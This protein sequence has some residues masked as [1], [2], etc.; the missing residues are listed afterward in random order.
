MS[1]SNTVSPLR[2]RMIED[3]TAR[4]LGHHSQRSHIY[5]CKLFAAFLKRSPDTATA[6]DV[7]S[8]QLHLIEAGHSVGNRNRIMTGV[9][10]LL[11]VTLRRHDL[12]AEIY[13]LPEPQRLPLTMSPD[14]AEQLLE[15]AGSLRDQMMLSL[16]YGCG[17]RAGEIVRLRA[18]DIDS[19][20]MI[21]RILQSKG[22]KDRHVMLPPELLQPLRQWWKARPTRFDA[23]VPVRERW[24]FPGRRK[25]QHLTYRQLSR[26]FHEAAAAAGITKRVSLHSLRHSFATDLLEKGLDI[27]YIQA[28]LGHSKLDTT[29]RYTRVAT[30]RIAAIDSP[31]KQLSSKHRKLRKKRRSPKA[32]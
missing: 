18:G 16:G 27:R 30:G 31:L 22:R 20:Q 14:E 26:I 11:R 24:L 2:Q 15:G 13:H 25:G 6:D 8:F 12:A 1:T 4:N 3:M 32:A 23:D 7:R 28:L 19:A 17:L 10:F 9:K 21:I 29:S 5:S